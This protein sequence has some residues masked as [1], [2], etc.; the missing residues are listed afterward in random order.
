MSD[1]PGK[2]VFLGSSLIFTI[3]K[4]QVTFL[5]IQYFHL[6]F[7]VLLIYQENVL[8]FYRKRDKDIETDLYIVFS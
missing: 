2:N 4:V 1:L 5:C 3:C 8:K 6:L 7:I